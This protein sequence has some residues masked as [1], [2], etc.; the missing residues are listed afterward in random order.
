MGRKQPFGSRV[1]CKGLTGTR[2]HTWPGLVGYCCKDMHEQ[3]FQVC[4]CMASAAGHSHC[5]VTCDSAEVLAAVL[6]CVVHNITQQDV[7]EGQVQYVM[8]GKDLEKNRCDGL[9][10]SALCLQSGSCGGPGP[11]RCCVCRCALTLT[12]LWARARVFY[13]SYFFRLHESIAHAEPAAGQGPAVQY[14]VAGA[15]MGSSDV[16]FVRVDA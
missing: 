9:H 7:G 5:L 4:I 16:R 10:H 14:H 8:Y 2:L 3:H 6:Q 1:M 12:N 15:Q 11:S 13:Q